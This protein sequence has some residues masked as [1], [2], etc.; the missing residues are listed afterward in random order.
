MLT[1]I[2]LSD[3]GKTMKRIRVLN[4][5]VAV[6]STETC[7]EIMLSTGKTYQYN[8]TFGLIDIDKIQAVMKGS[9]YG[10]VVWK[11]QYRLDSMNGWTNYGF[12]ARAKKEMEG[13]KE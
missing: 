8:L 2:D 6:E 4:S 5:I 10:L 13:G 7:I 9:H 3:D 12:I 11:D 1:I